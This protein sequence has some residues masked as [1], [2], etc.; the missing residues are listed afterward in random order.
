MKK[1]VI[2]LTTV[3]ILTVI[4]SH[5]LKAEVKLPA[6]FTDNMVLQQQ[7]DAAFWGKALPGASVTVKT[8]WNGKSFSARADKDGNWK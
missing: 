8:S 2:R 4:Q 1:L 7:T 5:L 6:I 3:L